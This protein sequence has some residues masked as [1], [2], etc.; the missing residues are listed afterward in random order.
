MKNHENADYCMNHDEW[1]PELVLFKKPQTPA[2]QG[3]TARL[4]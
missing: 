1:P 2:G 3:K 4:L